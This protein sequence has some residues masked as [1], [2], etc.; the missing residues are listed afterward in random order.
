MEQGFHIFKFWLLSSG[1][2]WRFCCMFAVVILWNRPE[3]VEDKIFVS[4]S[5]S[6]H[7]GHFSLPSEGSWIQFW[8][9]IPFL[10]VL[11][12]PP[13]PEITIMNNKDFK[14]NLIYTYVTSYKTSF[15]KYNNFE[16]FVF[17]FYLGT[18]YMKMVY[19]ACP[20]Q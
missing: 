14:F 3:L 6:K 20:K 9:W 19:L 12:L 15:L 8:S 17:I 13:P 2:M 11:Y 18:F 7:S 5:F 16:M 4:Q 1:G 10:L